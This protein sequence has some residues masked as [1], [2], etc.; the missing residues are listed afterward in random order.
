MKRKGQ[1]VL[2]ALA[3]LCLPFFATAQ[4]Q[5]RDT[6]HNLSMS[7]PGEYRA[8]NESEICKFCHTPHS[9][10]PKQPLWGHKLSSVTH[11]Q[12]YQSPTFDAGMTGKTA[13]NV[14]GNSRLCMS[15]HD[16]TVALGAASNDQK[17]DIAFIQ[18]GGTLLPSSRGYLGTDLSGSHPISFTVTE[19]DIAR[20]NA[21]DTPLKPLVAMKSDPDVRLDA[22]NKVQCTSCHDAHSDKNFVT[23]GIHFWNKPTFN[24]VCMVCH[25][26]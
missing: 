14:D 26:F 9:A 8:L 18:G 25:S 2:W 12:T 11:Y 24:E 10:D 3:G 17:N 13:S 6:R 22:Y 15:C 20:N 1:T 5:I 16:G 21:K 19:M 23:S 4:G 7:G